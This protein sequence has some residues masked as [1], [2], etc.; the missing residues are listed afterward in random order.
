[1]RSLGVLLKDSLYRALSQPGRNA[2]VLIVCLLPGFCLLQWA[3]QASGVTGREAIK[4][5]ILEGRFQDLAL[6]AV[7]GAFAKLLS[8]IGSISVMLAMAAEEDGEIWTVREAM[9]RGLKAFTPLLW[10]EGLALLFVLGGFILLII[11]GILLGIRYM[12]VRPAVLL[13]GRRG[14]EALARS[15]EIMLAHT[16]KVIGNILCAGFLSLAA[17]FVLAI[18]YSI[19][20][21]LILPTLQPFAQRQFFGFFE[22]LAGQLVMTWVFAFIVLLYRD[23]SRLHPAPAPGN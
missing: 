16:G 6:V 13:D 7:V 17:L 5:A 21:L 3:M 1:M 18:P 15:K 22:E 2:A 9:A 20:K 4:P 10:A 23:L 8:L 12:L 14:L 19:L 11:P